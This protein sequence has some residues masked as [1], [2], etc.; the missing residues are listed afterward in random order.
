M[1]SDLIVKRSS[2]MNIGAVT[3]LDIFEFINYV[4]SKRNKIMM[5]HTRVTHITR[6]SSVVLNRCHAATFF[7]TYSN[8]T[9]T[10][11]AILKHVEIIRRSPSLS[12]P[13]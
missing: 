7:K 4:S 2:I 5:R 9:Y 8:A 13:L 6:S 12:R 3:Y 1:V 11:P 10:K